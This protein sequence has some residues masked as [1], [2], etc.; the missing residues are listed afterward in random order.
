MRFYNFF[1]LV[2]LFASCKFHS[3]RDRLFTLPGE[4][5]VPDSVANKIKQR[6]AKGNAEDF[7]INGRQ[8]RFRRSATDTNFYVIQVKQGDKWFTNLALQMPQYTFQLTRDFDLDNNFDLCFLE[9][10]HLNIY[11][12]DQ[13]TRRFLSTPMQFS[14]DCSLLD[15][16]KLIYGV[17][18]HTGHNW[19]V[20]IFSIKDRKKTYLYKL[21]LLLKDNTNNGGFA[22]TNAFIYKCQNGVDRDTTLIKQVVVNKQFDD[23]SLLHFM[24]DVVHNKAYH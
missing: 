22:I 20:D 8:F 6:I 10:G 9:Y 1:F 2:L 18:N 19:D 16:A 15:S 12:F 4:W 7:S 14:Y 17:N 3:Q 23:F 13:T 5:P 24:K 11:F 21:K